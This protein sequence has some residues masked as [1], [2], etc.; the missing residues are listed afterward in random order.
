MGKSP[1]DFEKRP[2][3]KAVMQNPP[4]PTVPLASS[5]A[6]ISSKPPTGPSELDP[7]FVE[8]F[9]KTKVT[10]G[11]TKQ[12]DA[13]VPLKKD[14]VR[15]EGGPETTVEKSKGATTIDGAGVDALVAALPLKS[16]SSSSASAKMPTAVAE[17]HTKLDPSKPEG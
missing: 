5:A 8:R 17:T 7:S 3:V 2:D 16:T 12:D 14:L 15:A 11:K 9:S 6:P 4:T 10:D 13:D 1:L